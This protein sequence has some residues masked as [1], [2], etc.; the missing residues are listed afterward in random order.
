M[1]LAILAALLL[2]GGFM[3]YSNSGDRVA[4]NASTTTGMSKGEQTRPAFPDAANPPAKK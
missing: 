2:V 4:N 1:A 3:L